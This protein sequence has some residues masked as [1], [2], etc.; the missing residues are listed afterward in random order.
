[1]QVMACTLLHETAV[2]LRSVLPQQMRLVQPT[3]LR[4]STLL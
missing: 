1:M 3:L 2:L 4:S